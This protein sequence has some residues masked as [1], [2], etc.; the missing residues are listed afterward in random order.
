MKLALALFT[1]PCC[2]IPYAI[3]C[4]FP[5]GGKFKERPRC[6]EQTEWFVLKAS[7]LFYGG[8]GILRGGVFHKLSAARSPPVPPTAITAPAWR[9]CPKG[10]LKGKVKKSFQNKRELLVGKKKTKLFSN[11]GKTLEL[12]G[13]RRFF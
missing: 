7:D 12:W 8:G 6:S 11:V 13:R 3:H 10:R 5:T 4:S 9:Y 2:L 1:D